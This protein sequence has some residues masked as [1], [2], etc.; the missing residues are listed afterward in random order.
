[1][2]ANYPG[3]SQ[4]SPSI[5]NTSHNVAVG[6]GGNPGNPGD[7]SIGNRVVY[8]SASFVNAALQ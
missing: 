3:D 2:T 5:G 1:V 7:P 4:D 8:V 6:G